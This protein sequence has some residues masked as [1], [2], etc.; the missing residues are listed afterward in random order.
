M[1][2]RRKKDLSSRHSYARLH[3][4]PPTRSSA[5]IGMSQQTSSLSSAE[6]FGG[7]PSQVHFA[8]QSPTS[9]ALVSGLGKDREEALK[10]FEHS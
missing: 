6:S 3:G 9:T 5:G 10:F 1:E 7:N 2:R 4:V 8:D